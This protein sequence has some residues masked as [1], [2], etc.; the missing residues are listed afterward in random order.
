[1][2]DP[3]RYSYPQDPAIRDRLLPRNLV[4]T[5]ATDADDPTVQPSWGKIGKQRIVDEGPLAPGPNTGRTMCGGNGETTGGAKYDM[6]TF[7]EVLVG[8][9]IAFMKKAKADNK[10][11]FVWH[12]TTRMHVWSFLCEAYKK[13]MNPD[14]NYGLEEAGM[15][16]LDD[17]VGALL[18]GLEDTG[19]ANNTIVVFISLLVSL[20]PLVQAIPGY[21][22][23]DTA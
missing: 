8:Q 12:N 7:D 17:S 10:P 1:M 3:F 16:Q 11:F 2:S 22:S 13:Q 20:A 9:S 21:S 18:K 19:E 23:C 14:T 6:T 4:H 15:A 5:Y